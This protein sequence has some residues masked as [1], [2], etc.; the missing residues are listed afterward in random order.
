MRFRRSLLAIALSLGLFGSAAADPYAVVTSPPSPT[1]GYTQGGYEYNVGG[2]IL[3]QEMDGSGHFVSS[4]NGLPVICESG[5]SGGGGGGT[6]AISQTTAGQTNG[7]TNADNYGS[8]TYS[9]S[10]SGVMG[11]I[12]NTLGMGSF[13]VAFT[14]I[15][16]PSVIAAQE[17][18]DGGVTWYTV[19]TMS[20]LGLYTFNNVGLQFRVNVTTYGGSATNT[21]IV[22]PRGNPP[23]PMGG[24]TGYMQTPVYT[25]GC[26]DGVSASGA[27]NTIQPLGCFGTSNLLAIGITDP[28][29]L[30]AMSST[31]TGFSSGMAGLAVGQTVTGTGLGSKIAT[32]G[33]AAFNANEYADTKVD[34]E[35]DTPSA[36][37]STG[38]FAPG[39]TGV[40]WSLCRAA[41][42]IK[43]LQVT[44]AGVA[45][46]TGGIELD[47]ILTKTAAPSGGT[48]TT[49]TEASS[50]ATFQGNPTNSAVKYY[51]AAP[52]AGTVSANLYSTAMALPIAGT[53]NAPV[54]INFGQLIGSQALILRS[55]SACIEI[56]TPSTLPTGTTLYITSSEKDE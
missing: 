22:T 4:T 19:G 35:N 17:S 34:A 47:A 40:V 31:G 48:A 53:P 33:F 18:G 30:S 50:D 5:C 43:V 32:Q 2:G 54:V 20:A 49:V 42:V 11:T 10:A 45:T 46:T 37:T 29:S 9:T 38:G 25:I 12:T 16:G 26:R 21:V 39:G 51:T 41:G 3:V 1:A 15:S 8:T 7:I 44:V 52:T 23:G 56:S 24:G 28:T 13:A 36:F 6:V 27:V 55:A 14:A